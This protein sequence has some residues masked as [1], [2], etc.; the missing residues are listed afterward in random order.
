MARI[1]FFNAKNVMEQW[2]DQPGTGQ[3]RQKEPEPGILATEKGTEKSGRLGLTRAPRVAGKRPWFEGARVG[4]GYLYRRVARSCSQY[5]S[6]LF[7]EGMFR[8]SSCPALKLGVVRGSSH[9]LT[10][11]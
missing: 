9:F 11:E 1:G 6:L 3:A 2:L 10:S 5:T 4:R 7:G 8:V